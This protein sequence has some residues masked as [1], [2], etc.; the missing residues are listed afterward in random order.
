MSQ[1]TAQASKE[2]VEEAQWQDHRLVVAHNPQRAAEQT[3]QRL[4]KIGTL[5][6]LADQLASKLDAQD[7]GSV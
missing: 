2:V 7:G 3:Q 5:Q 6:Q 4:A 1:K